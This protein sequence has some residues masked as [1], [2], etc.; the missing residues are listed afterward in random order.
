[1]LYH[2]TQMQLIHWQICDILEDI[3]MNVIQW[4]I[5]AYLGLSPSFNDFWQKKSNST[6]ICLSIDVDMKIMAYLE[7][8]TQTVMQ[9]TSPCW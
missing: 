6:P 5:I 9:L 8:M 2:E 4:A 7:R 1:M 3:L